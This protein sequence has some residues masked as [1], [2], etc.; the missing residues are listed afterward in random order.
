VDFNTEQLLGQILNIA[1]PKTRLLVSTRKR[2]IHQYQVELN[3]RLQ[4]QNI[5]Q[6]AD[7]LHTQYKTTTTPSQW[8]D[9]QAKTLDKYITTC[10]LIAEATIHSHNMDDFSPKKV[11]AADIKKFWK[12]AL[13]ANR[14]NASTP[15]PPMKHIVTR[16]PMMDTEGLNDTLTI[17]DNL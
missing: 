13:Q 3:H 4:A 15:T 5:Y 16:Y 9:E 2:S 14:S 1:K 10:M 12:L 6:R 7:K 8:M 11:E 17:I